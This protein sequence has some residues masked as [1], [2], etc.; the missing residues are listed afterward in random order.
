MAT[1][2]SHEVA[3]ASLDS[4]LVFDQLPQTHVCLFVC[5]VTLYHPPNVNWLPF[6]Q[7]RES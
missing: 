5:L 4:L 2:T 6:L 3:N 1:N 7:Q